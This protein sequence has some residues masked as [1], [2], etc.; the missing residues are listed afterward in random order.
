METTKKYHIITLHTF[1]GKL[2][3]S[4]EILE[5]ILYKNYF[6]DWYLTMD[7]NFSH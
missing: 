3:T 1:L 4:Q 7:F 5:F 2:H 6:I